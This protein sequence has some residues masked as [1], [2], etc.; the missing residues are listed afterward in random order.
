MKFAHLADCHI[1]GW[2][3]QELKELG[4]KSF[5]KAVDIC[6]NE[7]VGF[8][9]ISGDLFDTSLPSI[10]LLKETARIL[11]KLKENDISVYVV[12]GSH[13]FSPSGKSIL[14][15]LEKAELVEN[16]MKINEEKLIFTEDKTGVK[17]TGMHGKKGGLEKESY[18]QLNF[19][20]LENE[21]GFKIFLFHTAL[22]EFKPKEFENV[23]GISFFNLPKNFNYYAGGHIH[24]IFETDKEEYGKIVF[25]GAL[26]PNNFSELEKFKQGGFY[27]VD[28][29]EEIKARYIPIKLKEV[30]SYT[31]DA[32]NKEPEEVRNEIINSIK[33]HKDKIVLI[34]VEGVLK[35]GSINDINFRGIFDMFKD[36]YIFLKNTN[37]LK[38]KEEE[39]SANIKD[40]ESIEE[41]L[42]KENA[43]EGFSEELINKLMQVLDK[44]KAEGERNSDFENR[45]LK[46]FNEVINYDN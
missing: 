45:I 40:V 34:R 16:V 3:E 39:I 12:P 17:L 5:E 1:G 23:E 29:N 18:N 2:R 15:V 21:K 27:I 8:V 9:V 6:I 4:I 35:S 13:D 11:A 36:A 37:K 43:K 28:V 25:P 33:E 44:E 32:N 20:D 10:D 42:I 14:D 46:D 31:F 41:S 19:Q 24:Y 22:E 38:T 7:L 30:L 26:F